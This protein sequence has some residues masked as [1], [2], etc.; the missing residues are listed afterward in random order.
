MLEKVISLCVSL[1]SSQFGG[2]TNTSTSFG[3]VRLGA[4]NVTFTEL[5]KFS[6]RVRNGVVPEILGVTRHETD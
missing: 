1:G 5:D 3:D 6:L 4:N 2:F